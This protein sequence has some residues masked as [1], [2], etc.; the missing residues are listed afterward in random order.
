M[1]QIQSATKTLGLKIAYRRFRIVGKIKKFKILSFVK[2][3]VFETSWQTTLSEIIIHFFPFLVRH[4]TEKGTP[5]N[6]I[7]HVPL[8]YLKRG[9]RNA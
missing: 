4:P 8:S 6:Q 5:N 1:K 3:Y 7:T 2:L 9:M